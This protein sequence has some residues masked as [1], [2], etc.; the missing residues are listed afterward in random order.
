MSFVKF[1]PTPH[2]L[3]LE[4]HKLR[5]DKLLEADERSAFFGTVISVEEKVDGTNIGFSLSNAGTILVQNRGAYIEPDSHAQF[6]RLNSWLK[7]HERELFELLFPD[8]ILFGEWCYAKHT[9]PYEWLP[10]WF[11]A[12]DIFEP[13]SGNFVSRD[14]RHNSLRSLGI[15]EV[16]FLG[17]MTFANES[18]IHE[19]LE[20]HSV[21]YNGPVEGVYLRLEDNDKLLRRAK[22]VRSEFTQSIEEHWTRQALHINGMVSSREL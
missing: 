2:L 9:I 11:L 5:N 7:E 10:D 12:F 1:P 13:A 21:L 22:I 16:P 20:R 15:H 4:P 18:Q 19:L 6:R 8:R 3:S 14:V 17:K